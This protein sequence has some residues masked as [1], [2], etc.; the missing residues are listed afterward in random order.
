MILLMLVHFFLAFPGS[1]LSQPINLSS[2]SDP[3]ILIVRDEAKDPEDS[4]PFS[5][6]D[7]KGVG[8][9]ILTLLLVFEFIWCACILYSIRHDIKEEK[10]RQFAHRRRREETMWNPKLKDLKRQRA[11]R[12]VSS[13]KMNGSPKE[14]RRSKSRRQQRQKAEIPLPV[15]HGTFTDP[16]GILKPRMG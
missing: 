12:R 2:L 3:A 8:I 1:T 4:Q 10:Y 15:W 9:L 6:L 13:R 5:G 16:H 11:V 14:M 7:G